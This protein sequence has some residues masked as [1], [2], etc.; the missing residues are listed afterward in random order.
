MDQTKSTKNP[1]DYWR[2]LRLQQEVPI[3]FESIDPRVA[4]KFGP[5]DPLT[6]NTSETAYR[7]PGEH[8]SS[9]SSIVDDKQSTAGGTGQSKNGTGLGLHQSSLLNQKQGDPVDPSCFV[10]SQTFPPHPKVYLLCLLSSSSVFC[11]LRG[12]G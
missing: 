6:W 2:S 3:W 1:P 10:L 7:S 8:R 9:Q 4:D 5:S 12:S 11:A